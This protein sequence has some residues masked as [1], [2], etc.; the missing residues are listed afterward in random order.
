MR[1]GPVRTWLLA[2]LLAPA[3]AQAFRVQTADGTNAL[4]TAEGDVL[5]KETLLIGQ[6]LDIRGRA[7]RDLWLA[8]TTVQVAG[9]SDG[10][11]RVLARSV[12][13]RGEMSRNLLVYAAGLHLA[14]GAVV[15]GDAALLG[16]HVIGEGR[17]EG[18]AWILA[19]S[20]SLG[21]TWGGTVRVQADEI[22]VAPGTAIAGDLVYATAKAPVLDA[23][24][25]VGGEVRPRASL[26]PEAAGGM[27]VTFRNRLWLHGF[28]FLAAL[29]VG[30]PFV[31][32][33]PL[34]AGG[35]V[36]NLQAAPW[37]SLVAGLITVLAGPFL[38]GFALMTLVG[39]PLALALA[40]I[41]FLLVYLSHIVVA[42][43]IGHRLLRGPG[44]QSF[45]QVLAALSAGLF[46]LY[47]A[48]ALPGVA[49]FLALPVVV[50]GA[51]A[52]VAARP[53]RPVFAVPG[54]PPM[55]PLKQ[56]EPTEPPQA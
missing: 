3:A 52:L 53:L 23:S 22:R 55:P 5:P 44:P 26:L 54:P 56:T 34:L 11:L 27:G 33:F 43:W 41:Y 28:L 4:A 42:L 25:T 36:R 21:G 15:R 7:E 20:V 10:D 32:V 14:T 47:F 29:L 16:N 51:G 38:I 49:S 40:A 6:E 24:V 19:R 17:V 8:G 46:L 45:G 35:A 50:L 37:R 39:I 13:L 1:I 9:E 30:M 2:A 48:A 12:A 31:G 18:D